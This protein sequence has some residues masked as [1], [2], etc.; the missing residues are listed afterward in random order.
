V[1]YNSRRLRRAVGVLASAACVVA[2]LVVAGS[3]F[4][5]AQDASLVAAATKEGEV[6]WYATMVRNQ[7]ARPLADAFEKKYPGIKVKL[8]TGTQDDILLKILGEGRSGAPRVDVSHGGSAVGP[9]LQAGL[10]E[11]FV[12][13]AASRYPPEYKDPDGYWTGEILYFLVA[14]INTETVQPEDEPHSYQD[15]LDLKWR[16]KIAWSNQMTQGG[17]P[18]FIGTVLETMGEDAGMRY[19][20]QLAQQ[21]IVNVP[22]NQRVVLDQV[23]A[24]QYPLALMTFNN[25]SEISAKKGAPVK[26]LKIEPVTATVDAVFLIKNAPHPNAGKLFIEFVLSSEGQTV[27]RNADYIPA[28]PDTAALLPSLK[29]DT[30]NF[31]AAV[32]AP[33]LVEEKLP[34]WIQVYNGLFK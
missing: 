14:A 30:G 18:G 13:A 34:A 1:I 22:A 27:F 5:Q 20:R 21:Q 11:R 10:L 8:Q 9:L 29:P 23:I 28:D 25:H 17:P 24:G 33:K 19:L 12:P 3:G 16:G 4:A 31:K 6:V 7:A 32:L 15:L 26:W 2:G